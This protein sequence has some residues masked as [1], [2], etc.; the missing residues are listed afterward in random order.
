MKKRIVILGAGE[1]G[2]GAAILAMKKGFGVFVSDFGKIKEKYKNV[3]SQFEIKYE[4]GKHTENLILKADEVIKS[5]GIPDEAE[6]VKKVKKTGIK[7]ISEIEFAGRY[8]SAKKICITGSNGKTTT[9]LLTYHILKNAGL[10]AGLA[11]NIGQSFAMQVAEKDFDYYVLEISSFQL[12]GMFDF[13]ADIAVLMNI[14]PD[15]LDRYADDFQNYID[16]KFRIT[17]N[18]SENDA[19]VYCADD[20]VVLKEMQKREIKSGLYPFSI[21]QKVSGEGAFLDENKM[22]IN[23]KPNLVK[24]TI[25]NLALQGKHNIYNSM[26]AGIASRILNIRKDIIKESLS[27]FQNVEHRLEFVA[28]IHGIDY[29]ND[30]KATN[31]NSTWYALESIHNPVIWIAGGIDKGNDY[32]ILNDVVKEKVKAIICL[33]KDNK[34]LFNVFKDVVE[35]IVETTSMEDAVKYASFLASKD[36]TVLLSPSCAS[37]DLFENFEERGNEFKKAVSNL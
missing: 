32:S 8:T 6:L 10:N 4:E 19:F 12:D 13:K 18:Q 34:K 2:V 16:S 17:R 37:F 29:I 14:T 23:I 7:V 35:D 5:P 1:S 22:L 33:G 26:A 31:V 11:G 15:H 30:S 24:M 28:S 21:K 9:T 27:D 36:D 25:E 20:T 3:L